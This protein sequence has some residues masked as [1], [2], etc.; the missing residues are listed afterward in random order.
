MSFSQI[1]GQQRAKRFLTQVMAREK[2]PHAYL[3]TGIPGI[4]KTSMAKGMA[5]ALNCHEPTEGEGCNR[6]PPCRQITSGN[7]PDFLSL[8]P[9]GHNIK[10]DQ[11]REL[12]RRLSFAPVSGR[13]RVCVIHQAESMTREAANSFLKALEEPPQGNILILNATEPLDLLPTIVSRCQRVPFQP[14]TVQDITD[15][16]VGKSGL[17]EEK[18]LVLAKVCGGSLGR[19]LKMSKGDFLEKRQQW[20][21]RLIGLPAMPMEKALAM[22]LECA[23]EDKDMDLD[24]TESGEAGITDMLATWKMWYRDLLL[25][26]EEGPSHLLINVDFS[27]KLKSIARSFKIEKLG[28]SLLTIDQAQRDLR[29][30]RNAT[31]VMEHAVLRLKQLVG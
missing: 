22:A 25:V 23:G 31:L 19:A 10:I 5:K 11:I 17:D 9:D 24:L 21:S 20:L 12:N 18:A 29:A 27:H 4:G 2:L 14:L 28:D 15:W 16:L 8:K 3:F 26:K 7:F 13:Y 1:L 6:C 30:K